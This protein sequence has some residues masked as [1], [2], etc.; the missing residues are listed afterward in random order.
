[1]LRELCEMKY[2]W[3]EPVLLDDQKLQGFLGRMQRT[4][5]DRALRA[6]LGLDPARSLPVGSAGPRPV[7]L[8]PRPSTA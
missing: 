2:L 7:A 4:P 1:M 8:P 5:L 6:A 3:D